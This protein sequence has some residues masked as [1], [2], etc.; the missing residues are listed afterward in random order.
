[1]RVLGVV[2]ILLA[3]LVPAAAFSQSSSSTA[4]EA[5]TE[6]RLSPEDVIDVRVWGRPDLSG[7]IKVEFSGRVQLPLLGRIDADGR[8]T[9]DLGRELTERYQLLDPSVPDVAVS[10]SQYNSQSV[11]VV[12]EVRNPGRQ[13]FREIPDLWAVI[14]AAGGA[15]PSAD[16]SQVEIIHKDPKKGEP[17]SATVDLSQGVENTEVESI[18]EIR[19]K[20][21]IRVPSLDGAVTG[22]KFHVLGA[23]RA[24][25]SYRITNARSA[26]TVVEAMAISGGP[27]AGADLSHVHLTRATAE[28]AV[29]YRLD[30]ESYLYEARPM[31]D[32]EIRPGDTVTV[33]EGGNVLRSAVDWSLRVVP[34]A[35][36]IIG[37][38]LA[39]R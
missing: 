1:M 29:S 30:L 39:A 19:P 27:L 10:V 17:R 36:S 22:D 6:Y 13:E 12:G 4:S 37:V 5:K 23:V 9:A 25:G 24:P 34:L 33:P 16:L 8:T 31:A 15:T 28:G 20:D 14:L 38:Y 7:L 18:P 11:T 21:T 35:T 26:P 2:P 3:L 32:M